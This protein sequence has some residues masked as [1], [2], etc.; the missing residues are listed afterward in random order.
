MHPSWFLKVRYVPMH[1]IHDFLIHPIRFVTLRGVFR[2]KKRL[3]LKNSL[4]THEIK[5][6]D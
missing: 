2:R 5:L 6:K 4:F 3:S 1:I